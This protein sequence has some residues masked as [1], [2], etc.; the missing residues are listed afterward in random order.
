MSLK[1][2]EPRNMFDEANRVWDAGNVKKAL[3]LFT[4]AAEQGDIYAQNSLGYFFDLGIASPKNK[5]KALLWYK[6]AA[7]GGDTSAYINIATV[8]RDAGNVERARFWF[9]KAIKSNDGDAA[10]ELGKLY[11]ES[12]NKKG[13]LQASKY[14]LLAL[15]SKNITQDS[16][17]EA[18]LLLEG[19]NK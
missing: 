13:L 5:K 7:Q 19:L 16:V 12:Q 6:K 11:L 14:L 2:K 4:A 8:Y 9:L 18:K 17:E 15:R 1:Q 3:K 10:L